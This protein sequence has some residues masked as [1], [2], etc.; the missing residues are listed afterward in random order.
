MKRR[1]LLELLE[2]LVERLLLAL[3]ARD[4]ELVLVLELVELGHQL[5]ALDD[6]LLLLHLQRALLA[7]QLSYIYIVT[8]LL[9]MMN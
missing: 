4:G 5:V 2:L 3:E 9:L 1:T 6:Q 8:R 7:L